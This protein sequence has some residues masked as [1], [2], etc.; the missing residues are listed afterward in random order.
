LESLLVRILGPTI[1]S[2]I[3]RASGSDGVSVKRALY[4]G[5][6]LRVGAASGRV[7]LRVTLVVD[8]EAETKLDA[9]AEGGACIHIIVLARKGLEGQVSDLLRAA[10]EILER[11]RVSAWGLSGLSSGRQGVISIIICSDRPITRYRASTGSLLALLLQ[12][13]TQ[14]VPIWLLDTSSSLLEGFSLLN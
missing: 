10:V 7:F 11:F 3:R 2:F 6:S 5:D 1:L 13:T 12:E 14:D 8:V 9:V 4:V